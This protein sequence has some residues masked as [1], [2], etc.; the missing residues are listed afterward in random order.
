MAKRKSGTTAL[1]GTAAPQTKREAIV[2]AAQAVF[3][4]NGYA[5][6]SMDTVAARA[7][8]SKATIYAYFKGKDELFGELIRQHCDNCFSP[9]KAPDLL[10]QDEAGVKAAL[11]HLAHRFWDLVTS[12]EALGAYR[13]VVAE[14][15][16]FPEIGQAFY[17]AGPAQGHQAATRF[18][19]DLAQRGL[20]DLPD[21]RAAAEFF[22]GML[23][24]DLFTRRLLGIE[25]N[26][27][28]VDA[29]IEGAVE[30][31]YRAYAPRG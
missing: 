22:I 21:P 29:M 30:V 11:L 2:Q 27:R 4:D 7:G 20:L 1:G 23:R 18:F 8:V 19:S 12:P 16:R 6:T 28:S 3:L 10:A 14:A 24:S 31:L 26:G 13:I 25:D 5:A 9:I 17:A 15:P